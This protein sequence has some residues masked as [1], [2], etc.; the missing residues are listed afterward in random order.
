[1]ITALGRYVK[2]MILKYPKLKEDMDVQIQEYLSHDL[3]D[4]L[5]ADDLDKIISITKF[6]PQVV[7]V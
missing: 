1:M 7:K 5:M 6:V 3:V 2:K 4:S